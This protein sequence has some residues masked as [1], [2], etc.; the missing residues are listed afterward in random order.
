[1]M[2]KKTERIHLR[3]TQGTKI[4]WNQLCK[5]LE[6]ETQSEVFQNVVRVLLNK[7]MNSNSI[8]DFKL[9]ENDGNRES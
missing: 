4:L 2:R 5:K 7:V 9:K 3:A 1:M 6:G 8:D